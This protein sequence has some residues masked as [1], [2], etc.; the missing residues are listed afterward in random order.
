V[1]DDAVKEY[2]TI[3][4]LHDRAPAD[5]DDIL[6]E[7]E[8]PVYQK[9]RAKAPSPGAFAHARLTTWTCWK[10]GPATGAPPRPL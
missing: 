6:A 7:F 9:P 5:F 4:E 1:F 10:T 2:V 8:G 3:L